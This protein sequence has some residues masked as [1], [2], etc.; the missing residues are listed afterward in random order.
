MSDPLARLIEGALNATE[1]EEAVTYDIAERAALLRYG[2]AEQAKPI[3]LQPGD[4]V[5]FKENLVN[6]KMPKR[7]DVGI[8]V[9]FLETPFN[10]NEEAG[11]AYRTEPLDCVVGVIAPDGTFIQFYM[12]AWRLEKVDV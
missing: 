5:R 7:G 8:L 11:S 10:E 1:K 4:I 12:N 9:K 6:R 3:T 2:A